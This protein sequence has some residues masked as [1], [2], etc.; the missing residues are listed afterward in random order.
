MV[1]ESRDCL[2]CR[3]DSTATKLISGKSRLLQDK[4]GYGQ[5]NNY[6]GSKVCFWG[7]IA[8]E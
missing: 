6:F 8:V 7:S 1:I 4:V 5:G 2:S 3:D